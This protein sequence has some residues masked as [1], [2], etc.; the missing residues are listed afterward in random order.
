MKGSHSV[1]IFFLSIYE[2]LNTHICITMIEWNKYFVKCPN[3]LCS[4]TLTDP[5]SVFSFFKKASTHQQFQPFP[6]ISLCND[7]FPPERAPFCRRV[8]Q[9]WSPARKAKLS[10]LFYLSTQGLNVVESRDGRDAQTIVSGPLVTSAAWQKAK[11]CWD[12]KP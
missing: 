5:L 2:Y 12:V 3:F 6:C 9:L 7:A 11:T 10:L 1:Y 8:V 4:S